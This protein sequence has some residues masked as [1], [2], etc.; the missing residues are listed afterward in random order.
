MLVLPNQ[1]DR[2]DFEPGEGRYISVL[3]CKLHWIR[4]IEIVVEQGQGFFKQ[5]RPEVRPVFARSRSD[6]HGFLAEAPEAYGCDVS[7]AWPSVRLLSQDGVFEQQT[8]AHGSMTLLDQSNQH[9]CL[10]GRKAAHL[11]LVGLF[12]LDVELV[13]PISMVVWSFKHQ[14]PGLSF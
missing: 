13:K 5:Y 1:N 8:E 14:I 9:G 4:A 2:Q 11:R 7:G 12:V 10:G 6:R 3:W